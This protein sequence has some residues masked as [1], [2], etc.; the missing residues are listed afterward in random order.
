MVGETVS[1]HITPPVGGFIII[2][3]LSPNGTGTGGVV[4]MAFL[5]PL[6]RKTWDCFPN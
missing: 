2:L 6:L 4:V 3:G 5:P 1:W